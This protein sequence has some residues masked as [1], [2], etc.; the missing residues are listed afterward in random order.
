MVLII[1]NL[2]GKQRSIIT[3]A[4]MLD[5]CEPKREARVFMAN[6][7]S[8]SN[9]HYAP[10]VYFPE[11]LNL[12]L[13]KDMVVPLVGSIQHEIEDALPC[14]FFKFFF[15]NVSFFPPALNMHCLSSAGP[16]CQLE[17]SCTYILN[18]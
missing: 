3:I 17:R 4:Q 5:K 6:I 8:R 16:L 11:S 12:L 14:S 1:R 10:I 7:C 13:S 2:K 9:L 15:Y 18:V